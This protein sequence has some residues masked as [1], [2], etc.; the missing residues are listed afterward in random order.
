[1]T[2]QIP[3]KRDLREDF[4]KP[5]HEVKNSATQRQTARHTASHVDFRLNGDIGRIRERENPRRKHRT[6]CCHCDCCQQDSQENWSVDANRKTE[7]L[8]R[9]N[10]EKSAEAMLSQH[11][12]Y[13]KSGN[14]TI[15]GLRTS[16]SYQQRSQ[17][18]RPGTTTIRCH[19]RNNQSSP[20]VHRHSQK[21]DCCP[22]CLFRCDSPFRETVFS[23]GEIE[24]S[25]Y[26]FSHDQTPLRNTCKHTEPVRRSGEPHFEPETDLSSKN[27]GR[28]WL[29][30][31]NRAVE[32]GESLEVSHF[33]GDCKPSL[34]TG[35]SVVKDDWQQQYEWDQRELKELGEDLRQFVKRKMSSGQ[36][37]EEKK[38]PSDEST[39]TLD[40]INRFV[41]KVSEPRRK[42]SGAKLSWE[43]RKNR[44]PSPKASRARTS[45]ID[46]RKSSNSNKI[47]ERRSEEHERREFRRKLV[48]ELLDIQL[49]SSKLEDEEE[50][51]T[52]GE[53]GERGEKRGNEEEEAASETEEEARQLM[54]EESDTE[55]IQRRLNKS[56]NEC[57]REGKPRE[58]RSAEGLECDE[59]KRRKNLGA[60]RNERKHEKPKFS[61]KTVE[62][63]DANAGKRNCSDAA[64]TRGD[65]PG[66]CT[67]AWDK[68]NSR[69]NRIRRDETPETNDAGEKFHQKAHSLLNVPR[70]N[71]NEPPTGG[72]HDALV[73][74]AD[75]TKASIDEMI[76]D[77]LTREAKRVNPAPLPLVK[78]ELPGEEEGAGR[79]YLRSP[80]KC[81]ELGKATRRRERLP[82]AARPSVDSSRRKREECCCRKIVKI[83]ADNPSP[84]YLR[85]L[86]IRRWHYLDNI[87][88]VL[89]KLYDLEGFLEMCSPGRETPSFQNEMDPDLAG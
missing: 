46:P 80:R 60:P 12:E 36:M 76:D 10:S 54:K 22:E 17:S 40:K 33:E 70:K 15:N 18:H 78:K 13:G 26:W 48:D 79:V 21:F 25:D 86:K 74:D 5:P 9:K 68:P 6:K 42:D 82:I 81:S 59:Q 1:M 11:L 49:E 27:R 66:N 20:R 39:D 19:N 45:K 58:P 23:D 47:E 53:P 34:E 29:D 77:G 14:V 51:E 87:R 89:A 84:E 52:C 85:K 50:P 62:T 4:Y 65:D 28:E 88:N 7:H 83:L 57:T 61:Y 38:Q 72:K 64:L 24:E 69:R 43:A 3:V 75:M 30:L 16:A 71:C 55:H 63:P 35:S 56:W 32:Q 2:P 31:R 67:E 37:G 8:S 73:L 41:R 44:A